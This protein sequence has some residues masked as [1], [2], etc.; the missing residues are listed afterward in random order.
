MKA[1][2]KSRLAAS[3]KSARKGFTL[4]ELLV[5][6]TLV[7]ILAAGIAYTFSGTPTAAKNA[8]GAANATMLTSMIANISAAGGTVGAGASNNVDTTSV[9]TI[10]ADL[11]APGITVN[12][13]TFSLPPGATITT[14]SYT[15][16][17]TAPNVAVAFT[18]GSAP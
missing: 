6:I 8:T 11:T 13:Q 15:V 9:A 12:G 10:I 14:A 5:C 17:G 1:S 2:F 7:G 18:A 4:I 16:S 3:A